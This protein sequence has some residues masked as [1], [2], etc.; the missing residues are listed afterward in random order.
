M[1]TAT[2]ERR[3][4]VAGGAQH[5]AANTTGERPNRIL[6]VQLGANANEAKVVRTHADPKGPCDSL[7]N[8]LKL[9]ANQQ[10]HDDSPIQSFVTS[11]H[12]RTRRGIMDG[13][14]ELHCGGQ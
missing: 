8:A 11:L 1:A 9:V 4:R 12:E 13:L 5:A 14:E 10:K 2:T 6:V 3:S 7:I